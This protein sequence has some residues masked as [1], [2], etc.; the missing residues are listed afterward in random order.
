M[1]QRSSSSFIN[2][3]QLAKMLLRKSLTNELME[4]LHVSMQRV[5][6]NLLE[7]P[8]FKAIICEYAK[9]LESTEPG[10]AAWLFLRLRIAMLLASGS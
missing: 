2:S 3:T 10:M 1:A 5:A 7:Q 4:K 9:H 6:Q 8:E